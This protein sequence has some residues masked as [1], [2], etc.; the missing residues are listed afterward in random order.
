MI[1]NMKSEIRRILDD[2]KKIQK[3][4]NLLS[5]S[6]KRSFSVCDEIVFQAAKKNPKDEVLTKTYKY[7]IELREGFVQ[8]V[9]AEETKGKIINEYK[10]IEAQL[11]DL[12]QRCSYQ[13]CI[14]SLCYLC[15]LMAHSPVYVCMQRVVQRIW[16]RSVSRTI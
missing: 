10:E 1:E 6:S 12:G 2:I 3:D 13:A 9:E 8:I 14:D 15:S 7:V 5:E 16:T 11:T 4:I